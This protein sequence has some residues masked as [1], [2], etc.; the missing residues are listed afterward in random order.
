MPT[1]ESSLEDAT[2]AVPAGSPQ[3]D[4]EPVAADKPSDGTANQDDAEQPT[5]TAPEAEPS[6]LEELTGPKEPKDEKPAED[7]EADSK[8]QDDPEQKTPEQA[9]PEKDQKPAEDEAKPL[10]PDEERSTPKFARRRIKNLERDLESATASVRELEARAMSAGYEKPDEVLEAIDLMGR[11]VKKRDPQAL[12][13]VERR[14]QAAGLKREAPAQ[15][16][17]PAAKVKQLLQAFAYD[18]LEKLAAEAETQPATQEPQQQAKPPAQ[19]E[20]PTQQQH[21]QQNPVAIQ[22]TAAMQALAHEIRSQHGEHA[23]EILTE[24]AAELQKADEAIRKKTK[25][26]GIAPEEWADEFRSARDAVIARRRD[27][28]K[29]TPPKALRSST[30]ADTRKAGSSLTDELLAG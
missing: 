10:T 1:D 25:G 6:L 29:R 5:T 16:G 15:T 27:Q 4:T 19:P 22:A 7:T 13:E 11:A 20:Q 2:E 26:P 8:P 17:I 21:Q 9:Q 23:Q 30:S 24:I 3:A 18:E 12:A 14:L 28:S